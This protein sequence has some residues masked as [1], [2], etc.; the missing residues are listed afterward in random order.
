MILLA[1]M[2]GSYHLDFN[3]LFYVFMLD[4]NVFT[5]LTVFNIDFTAQQYDNTP[6]GVS[7]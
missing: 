1:N 6:I 4:T 7:T 2:P 3:A 5:G